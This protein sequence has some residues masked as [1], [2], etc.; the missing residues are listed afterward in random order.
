ML[1]RTLIVVILLLC[2][3]GFFSKVHAQKK[4]QDYI[5]TRNTVPDAR[6]D[7]KTQGPKKKR[8]RYIITRDTKNTLAGNVCFE[9]A[10]RKMGFLY[11]AVPHGQVE[12]YDGVTRWF[13]NFGVKFMIL[14]RNGIFWKTKVNK[15]Y[16]ECKYGSGDF[17]G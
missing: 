15:K 7:P 13:H 17:T 1:L 6:P 12:N 16:K 11:M 14:L 10:T 8:I 3:G 9:E 2:A 4:D 5:P